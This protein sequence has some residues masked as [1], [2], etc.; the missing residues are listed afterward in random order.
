MRDAWDMGHRA[1]YDQPNPVWLDP[2]IDLPS[3]R[4]TDM[5]ATPLVIDAQNRA[6][7]TFLVGLATDLLVALALVLY[8]V[9]V[10]ADSFSSVDWS[11]LGFSLAK[12][13]ITTAGSYVLRRFVDA[14]RIPT[15]LPPE[16]VPAP[17]DPEPMADAEYDP[18]H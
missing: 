5:T 17:A 9:F 18:K 12:T 6:V 11:V 10:D 2:D 13:A 8:N 14:S 4:D 15:P 16:P 3:R 1:P 7:R